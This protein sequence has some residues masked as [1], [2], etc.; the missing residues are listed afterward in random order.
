MTQ[1]N[2]QN[3][4]QYLKNLKNF[5]PKINILTVTCCCQ[6]PHKCTH[7]VQRFSKIGFHILW[8]IQLIIQI[9]I[10]KINLC[11]KYNLFA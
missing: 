6:T 10:F 2:C 3:E 9:I 1:F 5:H 7:G 11:T 4:T 8:M